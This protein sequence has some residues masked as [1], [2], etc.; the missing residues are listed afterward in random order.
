MD[1]VMHLQ[2]IDTVVGIDRA[3]PRVSSSVRVM[4][5]VIGDTNG[6]MTDIIGDLTHCTVWD[7]EPLTN[8]VRHAETQTFEQSDLIVQKYHGTTIFRLHNANKPEYIAIWF[9]YPWNLKALAFRCRSHLPA[10][11]CANAIIVLACCRL[12]LGTYW[13]RVVT[14]FR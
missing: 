6:V 8:I 4:T 1:A 12:D 9:K 14:Y 5:D 10:A 13:A 7:M 3:H 2:L 11:L